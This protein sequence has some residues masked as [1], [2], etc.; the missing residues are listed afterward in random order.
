MVCLSLIAGPFWGG[1]GGGSITE[2]TRWQKRMAKKEARSNEK[3]EKMRN[4]CARTTFSV[5]PLPEHQNTLLLYVYVKYLPP[6]SR[7]CNSDNME[8]S[9][10]L[11]S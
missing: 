2:C 1:G 7:H 10:A 4:N 5:L 3:L 9:A 6:G 8:S 11:A